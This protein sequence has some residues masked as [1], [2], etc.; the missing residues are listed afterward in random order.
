MAE[1]RRWPDVE[2]DGLRAW[3]A[4][5]ELI[6]EEAAARIHDE[7]VVVIGDTHGALTLGALAA[8]A[9]HVRVH[10][11]SLVGERALQANAGDD[12][13]FSNHALDEQ[14]LE[15]ARVVLL[16]LPRSLDALEDI[17]RAIASWAHPEVVVIAGGRVKHMAVSM[18]EVLQRSFARLDVSL[19]TRK[20]RLLI[21]REPFEAAAP[22]PKREHHDELGL[23]VCAYGGVFAGT[24][25][26]IGTRA[27]LEAFDHLPPFETAIDLGSGSGILAATLAMRAPDSRVRAVDASAAAVESARATMAANALP[28]E[29]IRDAGLSAQAAGSADLIVLNPPFHSGAAVTTGIAPQL[30]AEAARVLRPGGELWTV[31][32]SSLAYRPVLTRL[33]GPTREV[34]RTRKFTVTA[35]RRAD[36]VTTTGA[37]PFAA[38]E[39]SK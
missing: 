8:G 4:A 10:Q 12:D 5:D 17:A 1:L 35:S 29:V 34:S 25:L 14:L 30:F 23:W 39:Q 19:A 22:E 28:V 21:V 7:P 2:G 32:N 24:S 9:P 20:S 31:W 3:D 13:R 33:V 6:L 38:G 15:G 26:D 37:S 27:L 18:N 16:R 36:T 11:D